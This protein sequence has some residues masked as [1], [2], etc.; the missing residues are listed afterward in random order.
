MLKVFWL[1][2]KSIN[3]DGFKSIEITTE[4]Y[5]VTVNGNWTVYRPLDKY[6]TVPDLHSLIDIVTLF[7]YLSKD[8]AITATNVK[9]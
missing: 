2:A 8:T 6:D 5:H 4:K 9:A 7:F 1:Q 3:R